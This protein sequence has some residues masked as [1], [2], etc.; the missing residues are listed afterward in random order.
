MPLEKL[1]QEEL[2]EKGI[3]KSIITGTAPRGGHPNK[4]QYLWDV[5]SDWQLTDQ[6]TPASS[7]P[8]YHFHPVCT[9]RPQNTPPFPS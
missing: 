9:T 5:P 2:I 4:Q 3:H 7:S 6:L 1:I 8:Q